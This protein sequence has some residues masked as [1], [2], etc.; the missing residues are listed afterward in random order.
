MPT[1][2]SHQVLDRHYLEIRC[3]ILNLAAALDRIDRSP[4]ADETRADPRL[5]EIQQGL[6]ILRSGGTD[7]AEQI[8]LLFSD[9]YVDGWNQ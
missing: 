4:Q 8:Q 7:R 3:E 5:E 2:T 1:M 6:D 9:A